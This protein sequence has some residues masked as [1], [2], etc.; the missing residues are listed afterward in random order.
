[1]V[2]NPTA[3][4]RG[5][6]TCSGSDVHLFLAFEEA[7]TFTSLTGLPDRVAVL[8]KCLSSDVGVRGQLQPLESTG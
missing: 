7:G 5:L 4:A 8:R 6:L 2:R 3:R 1:M